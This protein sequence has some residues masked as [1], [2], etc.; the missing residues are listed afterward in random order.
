VSSRQRDGDATDHR[1]R[2]GRVFRTLGLAILLLAL[3]FTIGA[4]GLWSAGVASRVESVLETARPWLYAAQLTCTAT[5]W[6]QWP[7]I[8]DWLARKQRISPFAA[9]SLLRARHRLMALVLLTQLMVGMG[10]PFSLFG[11]PGGR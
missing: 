5:V 10:L 2:R 1:A 11:A 4:I 9:G 6:L 8:I 3:L 7:R